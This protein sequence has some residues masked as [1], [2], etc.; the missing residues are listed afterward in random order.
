MMVPTWDGG[1]APLTGRVV[2][3]YSADRDPCALRMAE[4]VD[5]EVLRELLAT[6]EQIQLCGLAS[7]SADAAA[8]CMEKEFTF[9]PN[10]ARLISTRVLIIQT[11]AIVPAERGFRRRL[12]PGG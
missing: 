10:S 8:A 9:P 3:N 12:L 1:W 6:T 5:S 11:A 2:V 7:T 4:A